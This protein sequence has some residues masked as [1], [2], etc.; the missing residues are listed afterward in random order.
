MKSI[1]NH[2]PADG[3]KRFGRAL[4]IAFGEPCRTRSVFRNDI[5]NL[6]YFIQTVSDI[7]CSPRSLVSYHAHEPFHPMLVG[8]GR[9]PFFHV[10]LLIML[11]GFIVAS[12][13]K[14]RTRMVRLYTRKYVEG[15]LSKKIPMDTSPYS[16]TIRQTLLNCLTVFRSGVN[17]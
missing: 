16:K 11:D 8:F 1:V 17:L 9:F 12:P 7:A 10:S 14:D 5:G 4:A 15:L 2:P 6:S 13:G 3:S